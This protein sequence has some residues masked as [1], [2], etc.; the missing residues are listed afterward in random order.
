V[1]AAVAAGAPTDGHR[2]VTIAALTSPMLDEILNYPPDT[3]GYMA[4]PRSIA[5]VG[6]RGWS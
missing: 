2:A 6:A 5:L 1:S 3:T 4:L